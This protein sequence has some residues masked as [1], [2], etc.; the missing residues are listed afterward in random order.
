MREIDKILLKDKIKLDTHSSGLYIYYADASLYHYFCLMRNT[1]CMLICWRMEH[2]GSS[3]RIIVLLKVVYSPTETQIVSP[4][5][6]L[7]HSLVNDT[8]QK[9]HQVLWSFLLFVYR[10]HVR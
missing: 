10:L 8:I 1:S 2:V 6:E 9:M 3:T 4:A 7:S 5:Q